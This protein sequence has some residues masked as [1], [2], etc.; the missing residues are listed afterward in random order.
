VD[1]YTAKDLPEIILLEK[2]RRAMKEKCRDVN[3]MSINYTHINDVFNQIRWEF[4]ESYEGGTSD[5]RR[6]E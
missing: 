1:N 5:T 6:G 3:P 4:L 2:L